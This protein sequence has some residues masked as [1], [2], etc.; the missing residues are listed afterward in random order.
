MRESRGRHGLSPF[1]T[2]YALE[3][4]LMLY[5]GIRLSLSS[6]TGLGALTCP[7]D[8]VRLAGPLVRFDGLLFTV[9]GPLVRFDGILF[10]VPPAGDGL[11]PAAVRCYCAACLAGSRR[12]V[13]FVPVALLVC[14]LASTLALTDAGWSGPAE[15]AL[16][17]DE[18]PVG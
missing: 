9:P 14:P 1:L 17:A 12:A 18:T 3:S 11:P 2:W 7:G 15:L 4:A 6:G 5:K 16:A 13:V 8:A 10:T